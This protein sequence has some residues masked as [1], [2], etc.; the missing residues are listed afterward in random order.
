M[1]GVAC[2]GSVIAVGCTCHAP[3]LV[4]SIL[5]NRNETVSVLADSPATTVVTRRDRDAAVDPQ[6]A[7]S[8][9]WRD[10]NSPQTFG[11]ALPL[12]SPIP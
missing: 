7:S 9:K 3:R 12:S 2:P 4:V 6:S 10:E 1:C 11:A 8:A 5:T